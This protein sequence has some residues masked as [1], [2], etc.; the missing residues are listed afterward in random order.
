MCKKLP[1]VAWLILGL[2]P[3]LALLLGACSATGAGSVTVSPA[4]AVPTSSPASGTSTP[5]ITPSANITSSTPTLP[6][7]GIRMLDTRNGWALTASS[8]LKTSDGGLHWKD[9]TPANGVSTN[10]SGASL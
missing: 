9:V 1:H 7:I 5:S 10:L 8:I 3:A 6:L 4:T 2:I